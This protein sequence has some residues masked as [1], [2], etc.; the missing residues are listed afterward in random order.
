MIKARYVAQIECDFELNETES[1]LLLNVIRDNVS[2]T[3]VLQAHLQE[4]ISCALDEGNVK[5]TVTQQ[6]ADAWR[7]ED[8]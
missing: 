2:F 7:V 1:I 6:Y 8:E 4:D 3:Q 5:V